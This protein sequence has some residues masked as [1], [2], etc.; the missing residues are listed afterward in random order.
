MIQNDVSASWLTRMHTSLTTVR[1]LA[2]ATLATGALA[3]GAGCPA[4]ECPPGDKGCACLDADACNGD[5]VCTDKVCADKPAP[6]CTP[7]T[8]DCTCNA[9]A[10]E[11]SLE[12][13]NNTCVPR[14]GAGAL[15]D[16]CDA[17]TP[18]GVHAGD[19]LS[20][21]DGSCQLA[22]CLSGTAGCPCG[23]AAACAQGSQCLDGVCQVNGCT[24]G[25]AGCACA[26]GACTD[27]SVCTGGACQAQNRLHITVGTPAVRACTIKARG[28]TRSVAFVTALPG[29]RA[30]S[31]IRGHGAGIALIRDRDTDFAAPSLVV[32]LSGTEVVTA[33]DL[34]LDSVTCT[35]ALGAAV[36]NPDVSVSVP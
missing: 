34:T 7:G 13:T 12:C 29:T 10:C 6:A 18:C 19:T 8:L 4:E 9:G 17:N 28:T 32:A 33:A 31:A 5:L 23:V 36:A 26:S 30:K 1:R 22:A 25:T 2:L 20:C 27:G 14:S 24:A 16:A 21:V 3:L 35:D 11:G 15:N